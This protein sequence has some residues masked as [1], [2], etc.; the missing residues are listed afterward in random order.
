MVNSGLMT[1]LVLALIMLS[2]EDLDHCADNLILSQFHHHS[3]SQRFHYHLFFLTF[4]T[5]LLGSLHGVVVVAYMEKGGEVVM[6]KH[7]GFEVCTNV[8]HHLIMLFLIQLKSL[9]RIHFLPLELELDP[10]A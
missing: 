3:H 1:L 4:A 7:H 9:L 10:R 6:K 2:F 5:S 8:A